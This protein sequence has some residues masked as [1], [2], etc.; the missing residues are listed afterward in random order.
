MKKTKSYYEKQAKEQWYFWRLV[1][2][3]VISYTEACNMS[4]EELQEANAAL[5][6]YI[7]LCKKNSNK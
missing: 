4:E 2:E 6:F 1:M 3:G 5:N 7:Q